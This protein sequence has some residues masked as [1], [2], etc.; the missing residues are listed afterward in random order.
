MQRIDES[1]EELIS[2]GEL[3]RLREEVEYWK[4]QC[5]HAE[6]TERALIERYKELGAKLE[7][8]LR[9]Q[10]ERLKER[11]ALE[12]EVERYERLLKIRSQEQASGR[13][14]SHSAGRG[15]GAEESL[16]PSGIWRADRRMRRKRR[17]RG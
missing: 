7:A 9:R 14:S 13:D 6:E 4:E 12:A 15:D 1:G 3:S 10:E 5:A 11:Q 16:G 8:Q 17:S 2:R